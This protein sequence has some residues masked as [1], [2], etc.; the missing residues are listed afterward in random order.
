MNILQMNI[1]E[2]RRKNLRRLIDD[3]LKNGSYT[4]QENFADEVGIDKSYLSQML[5]NPNQKGARGVSEAKARQIEN[6]LSL[7]PGYLDNLDNSNLSIPNAVNNKILN[8]LLETQCDETDYVIVPI[9][10]I[11]A[12]YGIGYSSQEDLMKGGLVFKKS[13]LRNKGISLRFGESGIIFS[14]GDSMHPSINHNDVVLVDRGI[15]RLE[16]VSSGKI[17]AFVANK[18]LRIKRFF[19]NIDGSLRISSDN[20]DKITFPDEIISVEDLSF[21]ELKG[22]VKWRGGDI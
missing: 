11:K 19:K 9:F 2:I 22:A 17:Y 5:M 13:L 16:D 12:A 6:Q 21:I 20:P 7:E 4:L 18:E 14:D 3:L 1:K 15:T 10:D 8:S